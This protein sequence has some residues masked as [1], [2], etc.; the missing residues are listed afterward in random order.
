MGQLLTKPPEKPGPV[1][2]PVFEQQ[3]AEKAEDFEL[4]E[5]L[6]DKMKKRGAVTAGPQIREEVVDCTERLENYMSSEDK[7][8]IDA[9]EYRGMVDQLLH[10]EALMANDA[11]RLYIELLS[12]LKEID[13]SRRIMAMLGM[14][15]LPVAKKRQKRKRKK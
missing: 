1:F 4:C 7:S 15:A 14:H 5:Y 8:L 3:P 11:T 6:L 12:Y 2:G 13:K 9:Y 10:D